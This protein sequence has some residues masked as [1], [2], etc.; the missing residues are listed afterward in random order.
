[1]VLAGIGLG[2]GTFLIIFFSIVCLLSTAYSRMSRTTAPFLLGLSM[3]VIIILCL[4]FLPK[5]SATTTTSGVNTKTDANQASLWGPVSTLCALPFLC[6][7]VC[8]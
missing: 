3:L 5:Q 8:V 1:M 4:V 7:R 2:V 6:V